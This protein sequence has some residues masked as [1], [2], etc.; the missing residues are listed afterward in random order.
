MVVTCLLLWIILRSSFYP[1]DT[2]TTAIFNFITGPSG[3]TPRQTAGTTNS[4]YVV[5]SQ[6]GYNSALNVAGGT[7]LH[8][9]S[10]INNT[11]QSMVWLSGVAGT[12]KA[13]E[14][15][16]S[17]N[18]RGDNWSGT[19]NRLAWFNSTGQLL[20]STYDPTTFLTGNGTA[21]QVTYYTG[22]T[23]LASSSNFVFNGTINVGLGNVATPSMRLDVNGGI[24]LR[25][26]TSTPDANTW[27]GIGG[28]SA[29]PDLN[30]GGSHIYALTGFSGTINRPTRT[31][32]IQGATDGL[33]EGVSIVTGDTSAERINIGITGLV[34]IGGI[35]GTRTVDI[36]GELRVRDLVT[37]TPTKSS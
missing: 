18:V 10:R 3:G 21:N 15:E 2:D 14:I 6:N 17:G 4:P 13:L 28:Y 7:I 26:A 20:R 29:V 22:T 35:T 5:W 19:G 37:T 9:A 1:A 23:S 36:N 16:G 33:G 27:M 30:S 12:T 25:F 31:L 8:R 32:V 34:G 11:R 24:N